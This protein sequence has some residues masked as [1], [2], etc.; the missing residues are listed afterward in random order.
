MS[1]LCKNRN[2]LKEI[3]INSMPDNFYEREVY[4]APNDMETKDY[5]NPYNSY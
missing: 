3:N 2:K 4:I 1:I 5:N